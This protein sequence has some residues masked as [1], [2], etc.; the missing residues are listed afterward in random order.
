MLALGVLVVMRIVIG[1]VLTTAAAVLTGRRVG[2]L[3]RVARTGQPA[4]ERFEAVRA[5]PGR[6]AGI[7]LTEVSCGCRARL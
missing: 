5:H 6:N 1:L 2:W 7:Q 3:Y 4:P